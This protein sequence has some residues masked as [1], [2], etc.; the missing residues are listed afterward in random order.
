MTTQ[1]P[2][3]ISDRAGLT[4]QGKG[5]ERGCHQHDCPALCEVSKAG[6]TSVL[7]AVAESHL[8]L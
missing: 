4:F 6:S 1:S 5:Q 3:F 7:S 8:V 2:L